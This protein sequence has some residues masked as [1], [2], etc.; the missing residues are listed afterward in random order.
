MPDGRGYLS[1]PSLFMLEYINM[2]KTLKSFIILIILFLFFILLFSTIAYFKKPPKEEIAENIIEEI[3]TTKEEP[4]KIFDPTLLSWHEATSSANWQKRD[5]HTGITFNGKLWVFGGVRD[6]SK[7]LSYESHVHESDIWSSS[8]GITWVL[9]NATASWGKRR[10]HATTILNDTLY[11]AGGWVKDDW[12]FHNDVW[13]SLDGINWTEVASSTSWSARKGHSL[14]AFDDKLWLIGGVDNIGA[15]ND[16][17]SSSDGITWELVTE[18]APWVARYDQT[19]TSFDGKLWL[20]GG[21]VPGLLGRKDI[22]S[23]A[24]GKDWV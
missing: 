8:D 17:W 3:I 19:I 14:V 21:V 24:N 10:A 12:K 16:V 20:H 6:G 5:A 18:H 4:A 7:A 13:S 9:E 15:L 23:T 22:W 11:L 1:R 2:N